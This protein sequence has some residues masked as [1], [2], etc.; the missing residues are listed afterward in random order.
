MKKDV[1]AFVKR[2][3]DKQVISAVQPSKGKTVGESLDAR[4]Q[5]DLAF[6]V[7]SEGY[8]AYLVA[9]DVFDR[10]VWALPLKSKE[11]TQVAEALAKLLRAARKKPKII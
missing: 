2:K 4:W 5:M 6:G 11:P 3:G 7:A 8:T 9:V 10:F 1:E